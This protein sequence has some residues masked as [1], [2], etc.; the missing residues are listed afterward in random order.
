MKPFNNIILDT[1]LHIFLEMCVEENI[2]DSVD[3]YRKGDDNFV[4]IFK[5]GVCMEIIEYF[6]QVWRAT[7]STANNTV[8]LIVRA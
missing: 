7:L 5:S 1:K 4:V 2:H 3:D 8:Q 6:Q